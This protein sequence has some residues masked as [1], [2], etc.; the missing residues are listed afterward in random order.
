M[1][2]ASVLV[3]MSCLIV[4]GS[5]AA[6]VL[7]I[8]FNLDSLDMLNKIVLT[9]DT[10]LSEN[11]TIEL[12]EKIK[13]FQNVSEVIYTSKR[14]A[15]E[16]MKELYSQNEETQN[17]LDDYDE[18]NHPF[19]AQ[20]TVSYV[21]N[22]E[23]QTLL[24]RLNELEGITDVSCYADIAA[25]IEN[26]KGTISFIFGWFML[27]LFVVSIFV[28]INTIKLA[29]FSRRQ[30]ISVMRYVGATGWFIT[31]PF[32]LEGTLIGLFSSGIAFLIQ[33]YLYNRVAGGIIGNTGGILQIIPFWDMGLN[34]GLAFLCVGVLTGIIGS[35]IS[36][37]KYLKA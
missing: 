24:F 20:F 13:T 4:M 16:E 3:L 35:S 15:L 21:N 7:N 6:L 17:L 11:E 34:V 14:Q 18:F 33:W 8:N 22:E 36:L 25:T 37:G 23:L 29:V 5:F 12:G 27:I 9:V 2:L 30:E 1:T 10:D 26:I 19:P 28:I 31:L 32:V